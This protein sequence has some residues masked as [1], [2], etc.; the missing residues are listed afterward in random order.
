MHSTI[1]SAEELRGDGWSMRSPC[2][3]Q[4]PMYNLSGPTIGNYKALPG[5]TPGRKLPP[6]SRLG[7]QLVHCSFLE[8][9]VVMDSRPPSSGQPDMLIYT[10]CGPNLNSV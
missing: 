6:H 5:R 7:S 9:A 10:V 4:N 3:G 8:R 1:P 2:P